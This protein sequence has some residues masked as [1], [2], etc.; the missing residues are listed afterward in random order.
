[1][2]ESIEISKSLIVGSA[3]LMAVM[4][5]AALAQNVKNWDCSKEP[6]KPNLVLEYSAHVTGHLQDQTTAP[7]AESTVVLKRYE[8]GSKIVDVKTVT[9]DE[10]GRFDLGTLPAGKYRLIASPDRAFAQ[11]EMLNCAP[12][13][14]CKLEI[15]LRAS[16]TDRPYA[17]CPV[18]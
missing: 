6:V 17:L 16:G 4:S 15:T 10:N 2:Q 7:F 12:Q 8:K 13:N 3:L 5:T 18:Q 11:P 14:N 9:T 1:M